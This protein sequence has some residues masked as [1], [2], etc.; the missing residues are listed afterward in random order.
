MVVATR[1]LF[2]SC[3]NWNLLQISD[4]ERQLLGICLQ[5]SK[6][7]EYL[8]KDR[9]VHR[10]LAARN[11]MWV[12]LHVAGCFYPVAILEWMYSKLLCCVAQE[13]SGSRTWLMGIHTMCL[14]VTEVPLKSFTSERP[15]ECLSTKCL[16]ACHQSVPYYIISTNKVHDVITYQ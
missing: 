3:I 5:I 4:I 7:M 2:S 12:V 16:L 9:I 1:D 15:L 10:Y 8:A 13:Q 11:C 6:G 14:L